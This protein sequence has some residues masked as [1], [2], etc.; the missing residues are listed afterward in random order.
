MLQAGA[1]LGLSVPGGLLL[2]TNSNCASPSDGPSRE[3]LA[4]PTPGKERLIMTAQTLPRRLSG[5]SMCGDGR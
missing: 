1:A 5:G 4:G 3:A 2:E